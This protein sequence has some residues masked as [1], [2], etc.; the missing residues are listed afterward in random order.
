MFLPGPLT[1]ILPITSSQL[2]SQ[3]YTTTCGLLVEM[4]GLGIFLP[5]LALNYMI[6][7]ISTC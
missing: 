5:G 2:E 4:G 6:L 1:T 7:S 3:A